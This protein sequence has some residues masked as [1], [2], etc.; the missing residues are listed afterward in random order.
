MQKIDV[1]ILTKNSEHLLDK[2]LSS[3]YQNVPVND[4]IVIDGFSTDRTL[5]ILDSFGRK[6]GNV[7]VLHMNGSRA[8][9]REKGI[10]HVSTDWFMFVDSDV[11]L[12]KGWFKRAEETIKGNVGAIWGVNIDVIPNL[13]NKQFV[14]VQRLIAQQC[15]TLRGGTHDALIRR[16][17]VE[18]IR[19][20]EHLH[21]YEDAFIL[22]WIKDKGYKTV[23][24]ENIYCL[25]FKP[26]ENWKPSNAISGAIEEIKCGLVYSHNFM[27]M[28]YYPVFVF[29]WTL[30]IAF[31]NM[32]KLFSR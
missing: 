24:G 14:N 4:L 8:R 9:A 31:R 11:V 17:L 2:C 18:D 5:K 29:Y 22:H 1:V 19:I 25:H 30:Q 20:P 7:K 6:F 32:G 12:S 27:Y 23:V 28:A 10:A 16:S 26:P 3:V 15:F 13:V 21:T